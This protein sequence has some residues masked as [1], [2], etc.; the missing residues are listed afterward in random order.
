[1]MLGNKKKKKKQRKKK[2]NNKIK[3]KKIIKNL[4]KREQRKSKAKW[5]N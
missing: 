3:Y 5:I 2:N 4:N 1:M